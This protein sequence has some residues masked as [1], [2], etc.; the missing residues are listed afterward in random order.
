MP[1]NT[2]GARLELLDN[3]G[4][5][6]EIYDLELRDQEELSQVAAAAVGRPS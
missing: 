1:E 3:E 4:P 6:R 5:Y 2:G